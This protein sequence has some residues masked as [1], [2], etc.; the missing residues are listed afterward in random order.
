MLRGDSIV[1]LIEDGRRRGHLR[2]HHRHGRDP[3]GENLRDK[4]CASLGV[5][6][7]LNTPTE[8]AA[9]NVVEINGDRPGSGLPMATGKLCRGRFAVWSGMWLFS[10]LYQTS[11]CRYSARRKTSQASVPKTCN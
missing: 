11:F 8:C 5:P 2:K 4:V 9:S 1:E 7:G 10:Y 3:T 6:T